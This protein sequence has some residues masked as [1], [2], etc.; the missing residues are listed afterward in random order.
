[1]P[2]DAADVALPAVDGLQLP[3][4]LRTLLR[5]GEVVR[6]ADGERHRL[7]RYFYLVESWALALATPLTA[8]FALW[9]FM[10][11]DVR[12]AAPLRTFPRYIPCGVAALAAALEIVRLEVDAP[13]RIAAN[14]GYRSPS[15]AAS[16]S[17]SPHCWASAANVYRV[18]SEY[19]DAADRAERIA[20]TIRRLLPFA[21]VR[22]YGREPGAVDDQLHV[23]IGYVTLVPRVSEDA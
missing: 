23:D 12:E 13:M 4:P 16:A 15:H 19:V 3:P 11:V 21:W 22:P 20:G 9:E 1:M 7:P 10:D 8:H 14:G 17:P 5:P 18:G 6:A 2:V